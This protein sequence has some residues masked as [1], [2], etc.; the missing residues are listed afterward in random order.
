MA[1]ENYNS[2]F[3]GYIVDPKKFL[4]PEMGDYYIGAIDDTYLKKINS[5][6]ENKDS[7]KTNKKDAQKAAYYTEKPP[8]L[9][10][11]LGSFNNVNFIK[12]NIN[13]TDE[14][15]ELGLISPTTL[16]INSTK[17]ISDNNEKVIASLKENL[18]I[19]DND[20][21]D[22]TFF[23]KLIGIKN[24]NKSK[25]YVDTSIN[26]ETIPIENNRYSDI[27]NNNYYISSFEH[28]NDDIV[29]YIKI[30]N[31]WHEIKNT[32]NGVHVCIDSGDNNYNAV[33]ENINILKDLINKANNEVYFVIDNYPSSKISIET[34][35]SYMLG[36]STLENEFK[37]K[38]N[39]ND[40]KSGYFRCFIEPKRFLNA[41]AYIK[42]DNK[43]INLAK[44][45]LS[46][47]KNNA[48]YDTTYNGVNKDI[49]KPDFYDPNYSKYADDFYEDA[50]L[51]DDRRD[52]QK[53]IFG[54]DFDSLN[55]WTVTI[56]DVTLFVPPSNITVIST[57]DNT[58]VP[59]LRAKGSM[60]KT[61]LHSNKVLSFF[62]Y[63]NEDR[64]INGYEYKTKLPNGNEIT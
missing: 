55:D 42:I 4:T 16:L 7:S 59:L 46:N 17:I 21:K 34:D 51:L 43:W 37:N 23:V 36:N 2:D 18:E 32:S 8:F 49:F 61:G 40:I 3:S 31:K 60:S 20:V 33:I 62:I 14:D 39:I 19:S 22:Y 1:S 57:I 56:G 24:M 12:T 9:N 48:S 52:I 10:D 6:I 27:L 63:F 26:L 13:I 11:G 53:Q 47:P 64:G 45:M 25:W 35:S 50:K 38:E 15:I 28:N 30:G 44:A 5:I 29:Q 54:M 41:S 58:S